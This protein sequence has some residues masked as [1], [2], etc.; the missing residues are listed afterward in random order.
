MDRKQELLKLLEDADD[1]KKILLSKAIDELLY[2]E[3]QLEE[4]RKVPFI[5]IHPTDKTKQKITASGKAYEKY[6]QLYLTA[7]KTLNSLLNKDLLDD[8][9][10]FDKWLKEQRG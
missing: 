2:L 3:E 10:E 1:N 5:I 4:I 9:D 6:Y 8:D 7:L